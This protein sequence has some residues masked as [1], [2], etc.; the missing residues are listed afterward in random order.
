MDKFT[1]FAA[2]T[3]IDVAITKDAFGKTFVPDVSIGTCESV[4]FPIS[5]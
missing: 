4:L 3:V 2:K 1:G 5:F